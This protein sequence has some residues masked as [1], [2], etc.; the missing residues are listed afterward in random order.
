MSTTYYQTLNMGS[1]SDYDPEP[2]PGAAGGFTD[3]AKYN[4]EW[5]IN[6]QLE[7]FIV[8][9]ES[10]TR[11]RVTDTTQGQKGCVVAQLDYDVHYTLTLNVIGNGELPEEGD[12][13]F[14]YAAWK[15]TMANDATPEMATWRVMSVSYQ[16]SYNDKK[17]YTI[18]CERWANWPPQ[19]STTNP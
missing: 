3:L 19:S 2:Y 16:G 18:T 10:Y 17:K 1:A 6:N 9:N 15:G 11:E 4:D 5:G 7:G 14:Q 8:Q 12:V 13:G